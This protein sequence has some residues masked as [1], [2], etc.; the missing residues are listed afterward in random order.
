ME[1]EKGEDIKT[2]VG[3]AYFSTS[4]VL[5]REQLMPVRPQYTPK[6]A[7]DANEV[8]FVADRGLP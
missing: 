5:V 7:K 6:V 1:E 2:A 8:P 3:I 4:V